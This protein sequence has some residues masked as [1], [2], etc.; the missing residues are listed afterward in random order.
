M[1]F[2]WYRAGGAGKS[3]DDPPDA[4]IADQRPG[5]KTNLPQSVV[6]AHGLLAL[7]GL[8]LWFL[9]A[10]NRG[11]PDYSPAPWLALLM[12]VIVAVLG[13]TLYRRWSADR[14]AVR[15]GT[16]DHTPAEQRLPAALVWVH[17][18]AAAV[19]ILLVFL[20]ALDT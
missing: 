12:L 16:L 2:L 11:D 19:T 5:G 3:P 7:A 14:R 1:F 20:V 6:I 13:L 8:L 18:A 9:F 10:P 4:V 17:G 15:A